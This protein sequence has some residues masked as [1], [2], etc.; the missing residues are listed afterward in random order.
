MGDQ[1]GLDRKPGRR[2]RYSESEIKNTAYVPQFEIRT[3][4]FGG[5][6]G[7]MILGVKRMLCV[8]FAGVKTFPASTPF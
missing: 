6:M 1:I 3:K 4:F 8:E 5:S 7:Q 2:S